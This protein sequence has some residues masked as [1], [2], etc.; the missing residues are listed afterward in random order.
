MNRGMQGF[1]AMIHAPAL[2]ANGAFAAAKNDCDAI[3]GRAVGYAHP[4]RSAFQT[5][6]TG[7]G[8]GLCGFVQSSDPRRHCECVR[9]PEKD[10]SDQARQR[11]QRFHAQ[12]WRAAPSMSI[13]AAPEQGRAA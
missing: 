1:Q 8:I 13:P 12:S 5:D 2:A 10:G 6:G 3:R 4:R 11:M 7:I 9:Q